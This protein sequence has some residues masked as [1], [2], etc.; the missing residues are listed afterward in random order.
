M[1][2]TGDKII[3][4]RFDD[5]HLHLRDG[6]LLIEVLSFTVQYAGRATIMPNLRPQAILNAE[7]VMRYRDEILRALDGIPHHQT[8]EPLMAIE[9]RDSTTPKMIEK[10]FQAAAIPTLAPA[11]RT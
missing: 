7:D 8:F 4:R 6:Q 2:N 5:M 9:I 1:A 11:H 10:P 3:L